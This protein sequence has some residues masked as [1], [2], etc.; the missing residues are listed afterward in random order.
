[1]ATRAA[2]PTSGWRR[3][4]VGVAAR[5]IAARPV[6]LD[7]AHAAEYRAN[8]ARF[9]AESTPSTARSAPSSAG[10]AGAAFMVYHPA[11][12][13]FARE[14]GLRADRH[15]GRGQGARRRA[16]DRDHRAGAAGGG[17]RSIFVQAASP[18]ERPGDRRGDRRP[19]GGRRSAGRATGWTD[20]PPRGPRLG[21]Q[22]PMAERPTPAAARSGTSP[23]ATAPSWC[24]TR[25][26]WRSSRATTWRSSA[27]TAAA[28]RR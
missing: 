6:R 28:R 23:S 10:A 8:L 26:T 19:G 1:M 21:G 22:S 3:E 20:L 17:R 14:Y 11:W 18:E 24:S 4:T 16:A 27:P 13:Y 5:N 12:G 7:P 15:R 25:W 9:L 2:T